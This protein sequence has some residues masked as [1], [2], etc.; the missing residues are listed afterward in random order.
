[1]S[2][3][4]DKL[5]S[6]QEKITGLTQQ[7]NAFK[8]NVKDRLTAIIPLV[9]KLKESVAMCNMNDTE[10]G[11][12]KEE[13]EKLIKEKD[14]MIKKLLDSEDGRKDFE[15]SDNFS[16]FY[17]KKTEITEIDSK[18]EKAIEDLDNLL[19]SNT[20]KNKEI[21]NL[22]KDIE[23]AL[24]DASKKV[25][26]KETDNNEMGNLADLFDEGNDDDDDDGKGKGDEVASNT[27]DDKD[28]N[29]ILNAG[30]D[31]DDNK[32]TRSGQ[33]YGGKGKTKKKRKTRRKKPRSHRR[34]KSKSKNK[35]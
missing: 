26:N 18:I 20:N 35:L 29:E 22:I 5:R 33:S 34:K 1:M 16:D 19:S 11:A 9:N 7:T 28:L 21:Q 3:I 32:Q 15:K 30:E 27:D 6:L 12:K 8:S 14:G 23:T 4:T 10:A 17:V 24:D 25:D 13:L 31:T 2:G